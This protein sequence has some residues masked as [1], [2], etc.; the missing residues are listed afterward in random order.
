[1]TGV[2]TCALPIWSLAVQLADPDLG[3]AFVSDG[4]SSTLAIGEPSDWVRGRS[5]ALA[6]AR[7]LLPVAR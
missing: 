3:G 7:R 6:T 1:M 4:G 2:Q 5:G